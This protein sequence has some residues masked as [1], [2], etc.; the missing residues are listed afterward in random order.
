DIDERLFSP[1]GEDGRQQVTIEQEGTGAAEW[2]GRI[3]NASGDVVYT[4]TWD[5][6]A[7]DFDWNGRDDAGNTVADGEYS[8]ELE[9]SDEAGNTATASLEGI[10]VDT[11]QTRVFVTVGAAGFSPTGT[12]EHEEIDFELL[13]NPSDGVEQ[14]S[15]DIE[16]TSGEVVRT[17]SGEEIDREQEIVWDGRGGND[18]LVEG[19]D[20]RARLEVAYEK[21]NTPR[22]RSS[23]FEVVT[24]APRLSVELDHTPFTPDGIS[25]PDEV[26]FEVDVNTIADI[27]EWELEIRDRNDRFFNEFYGNGVPASVIRWDGR[28]SDG[29]TVI[30]AE[31]Y[32]Y[33][34]RVVDV[35]GNE[36]ETSGSVPIGIMLERDGDRYKVQ[37]PSITFEPNSPDLVTDPDDPRG[38]QNNAVLERLVEIFDRYEQY[39]VIIEGHAV[40]LTGTEREENDILEPLSRSRAQSVKEGLVDR[41][42][43]ASRIEVVGRG[44]R[45]P[46]VPHDDLDE[47]WRNRRVDFI[48]ER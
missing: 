11:R 46:M 36:V 44:G 2:T 27:A 14:W 33:T 3:R 35:Y 25:G 42:M 9:G 41:G 18:R 26:E 31:D 13:V 34:M 45:D 29:D 21:G 40:N 8:Y 30:S 32:P 47:R 16:N 5:G 24:E 1:D 19:G 15:L 37:I 17:F 12:G 22:S 38:V 7:E 28:A 48:L 20:Y 10:T 6:E 43:S 23:Q 39:D 4:E